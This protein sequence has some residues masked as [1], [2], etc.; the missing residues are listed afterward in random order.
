MQQ[1]LVQVKNLEAT[2]APIPLYTT[3]VM[4]QKEV[5]NL[6]FRKGGTIYQMKAREGQYVKEGQFL[7]EVRIP[8][9]TMQLDKVRQQYDKMKRALQNAQKM[10][11]DTAITL[12]QLEDLQAQTALVKADLDL[13]LF[14]AESTKIIS[15][16]NGRILK[17][18]ANTNEQISAGMPVFQI[19]TRGQNGLVFKTSVTDKDM[20]SVRLNDKA[21]IT[22][23]AK[24]AEVLTA[25]VSQIAETA[26]PNTGTFGLE[27]TVNKSAVFPLKSGFI[28]AVKLYPSKQTPYYK[29]DLR[30]MVNSQNQQANIFVLNKK[31]TQ[32]TAKKIMVQP[33]FIN[34]E[35]FTINS[36]EIEEGTSLIIGGASG[37]ADGMEVQVE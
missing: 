31:T 17:K 5:L 27:L 35:F 13:A 32:P 11:A 7:A 22:F 25:Y 4:V 21:E 19:A 28:G 36:Q 8:E 2:N 6:S 37:I 18:L 24:E 33:V 10:Y 1:R 30:A 34:N 20:L 23:D 9:L 16:T 15:P 29:I 26:N 12:Q 14:Q 3:G